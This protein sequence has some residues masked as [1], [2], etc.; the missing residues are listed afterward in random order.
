[1]QTNSTNKLLVYLFTL[2]GTINKSLHIRTHNLRTCQANFLN[3]DTL[4]IKNLFRLA[5]QVLILSHEDKSNLKMY[6][7]K[8]KEI[9]CS[10]SNENDPEH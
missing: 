8:S 5:F 2:I 9:N 6:I 7:S 10:Q 1:M 4:N 3:L